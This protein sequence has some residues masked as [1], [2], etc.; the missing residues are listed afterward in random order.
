M[1]IINADELSNN[2]TR[3][4]C[5][6]CES[7]KDECDVCEISEILRMIEE[8]P[9]LTDESRKDLKTMKLQIVKNLPEWAANNPKIME[10]ERRELARQIGEAL[11]DDGFIKIDERER[12]SPSGLEPSVFIKLS[13]EFLSD[14]ETGV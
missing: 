5:N 9:T 14:T 4:F 12:Y 8:T 2:I 1:R 13:F 11:L 7:Y 6:A 10:H 3:D